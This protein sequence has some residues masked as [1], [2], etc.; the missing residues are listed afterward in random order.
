MQP[1]RRVSQMRQKVFCGKQRCTGAGV[2]QI[3]RSRI[4]LDG[5]KFN[6]KT[7]VGV[8]AGVTISLTTIVM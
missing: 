5:V 4:G 8:G 6:I 1:L 7:G 3:F 2:K